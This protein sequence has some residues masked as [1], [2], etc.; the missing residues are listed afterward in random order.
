MTLT[1]LLGDRRRRKDDG[2]KWFFFT[3]ADPQGPTVRTE[4]RRPLCFLG[5]LRLTKPQLPVRVF[6]RLIVMSFSEADR[7]ELDSTSSS[8]RKLVK[9]NFRA[10]FAK[11]E[12][13]T[14]GQWRS[15]GS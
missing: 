12:D 4:G 7:M 10:I 13:L 5:F 15:A 11:D 6:F 14:G 8:A 1:A 3:I 2:C 9:T